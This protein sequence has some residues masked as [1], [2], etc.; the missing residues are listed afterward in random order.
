MESRGENCDYVIILCILKIE[1]ETIKIV[2]NKKI[3]EFLVRMFN[4]NV[5]V[6]NLL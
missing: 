6:G 4:Y 3:I 2:I 5:K 1:N